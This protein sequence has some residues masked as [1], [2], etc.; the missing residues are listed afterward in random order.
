MGYCIPVNDIYDL[1]EKNLEVL[2]WVFVNPCY[3]ERRA[4]SASG[5]SNLNNLTI[6]IE[7]KN[8]RLINFSHENSLRAR[9]Y[10]LLKISKI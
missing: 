3:S 1:S 8:G 9:I 5:F 4:L 7:L 10:I 2:F 6:L